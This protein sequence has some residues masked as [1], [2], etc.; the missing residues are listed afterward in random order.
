MLKIYLDLVATQ[1]SIIYLSASPALL[2]G[3]Q[4]LKKIGSEFKET[5]EDAIFSLVVELQLL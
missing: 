2:V 3:L 4:E 5:K 1:T